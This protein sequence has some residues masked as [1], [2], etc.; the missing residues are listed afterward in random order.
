MR[1]VL[2]LH[3]FLVSSFGYKC[4]YDCVRRYVSISFLAADAANRC[5]AR[6]I[7]LCVLHDIVLRVDG[8]S[9]IAMWL[10]G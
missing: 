6:M 10:E 9:V 5:Y 8:H 3:K 7:A 2:E 1:S 4:E